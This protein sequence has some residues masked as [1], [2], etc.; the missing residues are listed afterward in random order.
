MK[1]CLRSRSYHHIVAVFWCWIFTFTQQLIELKW[2]KSTRAK[3]NS[4]RK[5]VIRERWN[6]RE[7]DSDPLIITA[8]VSYERGLQVSCVVY[9][10]SFVYDIRELYEQISFHSHSFLSS[11]SSLVL[12]KWQNVEVFVV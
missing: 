4:R 1:I 6:V 5:V 10:K 9:S 8:V 12:D 2:D 11:T 3:D 7:S